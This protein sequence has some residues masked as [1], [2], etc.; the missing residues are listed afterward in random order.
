MLNLIFWKK[1]QGGERLQNTKY[2]VSKCCLKN[3]NGHKHP[4]IS[5]FIIEQDTIGEIKESDIQHRNRAFPQNS[6]IDCSPI[7]CDGVQLHQYYSTLP[8]YVYIH[9]YIILLMIYLGLWCTLSW[10][11]IV[12]FNYPFVVL[13]RRRLDDSSLLSYPLVKWKVHWKLCKR[14]CIKL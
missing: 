9:I 6:P 4:S 12:P 13:Y 1:V 3:T 2:L 8:V 10:A 11:L 7:D 5:L 14:M